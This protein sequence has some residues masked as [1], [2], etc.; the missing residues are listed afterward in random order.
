MINRTAL[1]RLA[2]G[3]PELQPRLLQAIEQGLEFKTAEDLAK[4]VRQPKAKTAA[5]Y[6]LDGETLSKR[7]MLDRAIAK[8]MAFIGYSKP[9]L[10]YHAIMDDGSGGTATV[11]QIGKRDFDKLR[12]PDRTTK[13]TLE[14]VKKMQ[15]HKLIKKRLHQMQDRIDFNMWAKRTNPSIDEQIEWIK[16]RRASDETACGGE[17]E[18]EIEVENEIGE[19]EIG[20]ININM[21]DSGSKGDTE[22]WAA[23]L[24]EFEDSTAN[25]MLASGPDLVQSYLMPNTEQVDNNPFGERG[26]TAADLEAGKPCPQNPPEGMRVAFTNTME[27]M[28]SYGDAPPPGTKGTVLSARTDGRMA[29]SHDGMVFVAFDGHKNMA[30]ASQHLLVSEAQ[31]KK[32]QRKTASMVRRASSIDALLGGDEFVKLAEDTLVHK[33]TRDLWSLKQEPGG[34]VIERLFEDDGSPLKL[35]AGSR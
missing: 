3:N 29:T 13:K 18:R 14:K 12:V 32:A 5:L 24:G 28:L 7:E 21:G 23:H 26:L 1:I 17:G 30:V 35:A 10:K 2:H 31:K 34:Y 15:L 19:V 6:N 11:F 33:A 20:E 22:E 4:W 9:K 25:M 8:E 27:A 16:S